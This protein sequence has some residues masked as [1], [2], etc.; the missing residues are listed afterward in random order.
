MYIAPNSII[1][2]MH[3]VPLD[4]SYNHTIKFAS[5]SAQQAYF[6]SANVVKFTLNEQTYQRVERG[7]MR[8]EIKAED[9]YDCDYLS[10]QNTSFGTKWFYAFITGVEY[11]NNVT[12]E[13]TFEI[14]VMQTYLFD[15]TVGEC[16]VEREHVIDDS[17]GANTI[18]EPIDCPEAEVISRRPVH[19]TRWKIVINYSPSML[20]LIANAVDQFTQEVDANIDTIIA[21]AGTNTFAIGGLTFVKEMNSIVQTVAQALYPNTMGDFRE[22]QFTG[23]T[24]YVSPEISEDALIGNVQQVLDGVQADIDRMFATGGTINSIYQIPVEIDE[25]FAYGAEFDVEEE[26]FKPIDRFFYIDERNPIYYIPKNNKL[27][28]SPYTYMKVINKQGGE[29]NLAY[30]KIQDKHFR[31]QGAWQ[32]GDVNVVM[33]NQNYGT[34][35]TDNFASQMLCRLP[36]GNF[37]VCNYNVNGFLARLIQTIGTLTKTIATQATYMP[38]TTNTT[39]T[40]TETKTAQHRQGRKVLS[41]FKTQQDVNEQYTSETERP[42]LQNYVNDLGN[43]SNNFIGL[44]QHINNST[45]NS[46]CD[47]ANDQLGYDIH[48]ME[49]TAEYAEIIDNFFERFGYAVKKNK[50]PNMDTRPHW[51]YVKTGDA[52]IKGNCPAES[53]NKIISIFNNGITFW[54]VPSE[55][56]NYSLDNHIHT[57]P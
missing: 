53:L 44:I 30:E 54:K 40:G 7:K 19:F 29:M 39:K 43:V 51:N 12:S 38:T 50:V 3:N 20:N 15:I 5:L 23:M 9:L 22:H 56:G 8:V 49:I 25:D 13:I 16:Y 34:Q 36:I 47:I 48:L 52:Y 21:G 10:F 45:S 33:Y 28:T 57:T 1:R 37:P 32:S 18:A 6:S 42:Q 31:F 11:V 46:N 2:I 55:V 14:D 27:F 35:G 26:W 17:I 4:D 24:P 41:S